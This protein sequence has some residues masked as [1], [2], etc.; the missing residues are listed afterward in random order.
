MLFRK[1]RI[2]GCSADTLLDQTVKTCVLSE[3]M[4][5]LQQEAASRLTYFT[6]QNHKRRRRLYGDP[7]AA[8][9]AQTNATGRKTA[10]ASLAEA[11]KDIDRMIGELQPGGDDTGTKPGAAAEAG[12][13]TGAKEEADDPDSVSTEAAVRARRPATGALFRM[14]AA[15]HFAEL[16][17]A[18]SAVE[19]PEGDGAR[20]LREVA[21]ERH[22]ESV[23]SLT[24]AAH[25]VLSAKNA[26]RLGFKKVYPPA[27][28]EEGRAAMYER[29][30]SVAEHV[31]HA[32][33]VNGTMP[34]TC[35][36][37]SAARN[38]QIHREVRPQR[39]FPFRRRLAASSPRPCF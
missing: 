4:A 21:R 31:Y 22:E 13:A 10:A 26:G 33:T 38:N 32:R 36:A 9:R 19:A 39:L 16:Q 34:C 30:L 29:V 8:A 37:C 7:A 35:A 14:A 25:Q 11:F 24:R 20:L 1:K 15:Q 2:F 5:I 6:T 27:E 3:T 18:A 17:K 28:G 23:K 12:P